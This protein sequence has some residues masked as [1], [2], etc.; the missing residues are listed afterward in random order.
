MLKNGESYFQWRGLS[1]MDTCPMIMSKFLC[2]GFI[3]G[4]D[5]ELTAL[6]PST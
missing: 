1:M 5:L 4:I 3:V 2:E 6:E